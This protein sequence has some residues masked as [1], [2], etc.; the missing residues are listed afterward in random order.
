MCPP[1]ASR[2][3]R[4][5]EGA[6]QEPKRLPRADVKMLHD[7]GVGQHMPGQH[8][9]ATRIDREAHLQSV[10]QQLVL[11]GAA[12]RH[13][14]GDSGPKRRL[15]DG[16]CPG[17]VHGYR[18]RYLVI[19]LLVQVAHLLQRPVQLVMYRDEIVVNHGLPASVSDAFRVSGHLS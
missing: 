6:G 17:G 15:V 4:A 18:G 14:F 3:G 16:H 9:L 10:G 12:G 13:H 2:S 1:L 7:I 19:H 11:A 8:P 5:G